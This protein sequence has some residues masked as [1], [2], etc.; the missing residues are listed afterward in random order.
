[1]AQL[2]T[3][4]AHQMCAMTVER[5]VTT[6]DGRQLYFRERFALR[7]DGAIL[8]YIIASKSPG[9]PEFKHNSTYSHWAKLKPDTPRDRGTLRGILERRGYRIIREH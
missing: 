3:K 9:E 5:D 8:S 2:R 6:P 4:K 7:S 1:M